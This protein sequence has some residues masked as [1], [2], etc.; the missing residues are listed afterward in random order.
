MLF[1]P[2]S[3]VRETLDE[4]NIENCHSFG[5]YPL[6][7]LNETQNIETVEQPT[8]QTQKVSL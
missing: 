5:V 7:Q 8:A 1:S 6:T 4:S 2:P 3:I